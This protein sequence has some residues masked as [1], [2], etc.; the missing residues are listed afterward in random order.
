V[1]NPSQANQD[2]DGSGDACDSDIDG[3]SV[4][5][6]SDN[7]ASAANP[8]QADQDGD[9]TGDV[10][11]NDRD[12]DG[13]ANAGD[14]CPSL[15]NPSQ[16]NRD[17]DAFGD[18]CDDDADGDGVSNSIDSCP[19][20][21]GGPTDANGDGCPDSTGGGNGGNQGGSDPLTPPDTR[22]PK[23][24]SKAK[25]QRAL[26]AKALSWTVSSDE[27]CRLTVTAK[28]GKTR[29]GKLKRSLKAGAKTKLKLKLSGKSRKAL[30]RS[31]AKHKRVKV[32]LVSICT[33]AAGNVRLASPK[34]V[35]KR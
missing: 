13:A 12:G 1:A 24:T 28:L 6:G 4:P 29:L 2:G 10:C 3:D 22:K 5:N 32:T 25:A 34:L 16:A 23:L 33:D 11:D 9:G 30:Q 14:N 20:Q 26:K 19:A 31:L 15:A 17:G 8:S 27:A 7:C 18:A 35:V 21:S